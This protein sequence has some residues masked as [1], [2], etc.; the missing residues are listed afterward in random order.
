[1][2]CISLAGS[3]EKKP[4]AKKEA[5]QSGKGAV[6]LSDARM[7]ITWTIDRLEK[8]PSGS[9]G[10]CE[11]SCQG[12]KHERHSE[13]DASCDVPCCFAAMTHKRE[14][15]SFAEATA[16]ADAEEEKKLRKHF[17]DFGVPTSITMEGALAI[18]CDGVVKGSGKTWLKPIEAKC[19]NKDPCSSSRATF[20]LVRWTVKIEYELAYDKTKNGEVVSTEHGPKGVVHVTFLTNPA[21]DDDRTLTYEAPVVNCRCEVTQKKPEKTA[22]NRPEDEYAHIGTGPSD[23]PVTG[24]DIAHMVTNIDV[25]DMNSATLTFAE[26]SERI[27]FPAGWELECVDGSAQDVEILDSMTILAAAG[28]GPSNGA[29]TKTVRVLCLNMHKD[30]PKSGV[31]YRLVPPRSAALQRLAMDME[32]TMT[33]GPSLQ[34]RLWIAS[35]NQTLDEMR[36]ILFPKPNERIYLS[37]LY[38]A[39]KIGAIDVAD[40]AIRKLLDPALLLGEGADPQAASWL[41][42]QLLL[43]DA[44]STTRWIKANAANFS[45][46]F[47]TG[48]AAARAK[49]V[50]KLARS[51]AR[52]KGGLSAAAHLLELAAPTEKRQLLAETEDAAIASLALTN[53][54]D[55]DGAKLMLQWL[56]KQKTTYA[57]VAAQNVD[58]D[59][60]KEVLSLARSIAD[61]K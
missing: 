34:V 26:T 10:T 36:K 13:C 51:A 15:F 43:I 55:N 9:I 28:S 17:L 50:A 2:L 29:T 32:N 54:D 56:A 33:M 58:P 24:G 18:L 38:A 52:T 60:S 23:R 14:L 5:A 7:E 37:Q 21:D 22:T 6:R 35:G 59:L 12:K 44:P 53:T 49:F 42:T 41:L 48:D 45:T 1:M 46:S 25:P 16:Y 11:S 3:Q 31:K 57:R 47:V 19:W 40:P 8:G 39:A 61:A 30:M 20:R 4:E 27:H